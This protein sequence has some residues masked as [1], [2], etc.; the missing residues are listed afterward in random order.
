MDTYFKYKFVTEILVTGSLLAFG[1]IILIAGVID[2]YK[3]KHK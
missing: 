3:R 2:K 1:I